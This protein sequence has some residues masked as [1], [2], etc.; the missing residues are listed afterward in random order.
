MEA[1]EIAYEPAAQPTYEVVEESEPSQS[2]GLLGAQ[3]GFSFGPFK[4]NGGIGAGR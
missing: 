1:A 3:G 2:S 4:I